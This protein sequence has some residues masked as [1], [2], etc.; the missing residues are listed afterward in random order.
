MFEKIQEMVDDMTDCTG[1]HNDIA[2]AVL[3][4]NNVR[5]SL[6]TEKLIEMCLYMCDS[7]D[8]VQFVLHSLIFSRLYRVFYG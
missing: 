5:S 6:L 2:L 8:C 3:A 7:C 1:V 4:Y